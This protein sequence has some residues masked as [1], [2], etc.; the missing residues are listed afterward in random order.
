MIHPLLIAEHLEACAERIRTVGLQRNAGKGPNGELCAVN[1]SWILTAGL[2]WEL[3]NAAMRAL[4]ETVCPHGFVSAWS[5]N[6][7][8][9]EVVIDGFLLAAA[10]QRMLADAMPREL[11]TV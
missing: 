9:D 1:T 10:R 5:D 11:V 7:P 6:S 2:N 4:T 8:S 3:D